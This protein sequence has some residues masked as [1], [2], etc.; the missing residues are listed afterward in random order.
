MSGGVTQSPIHS[1]PEGVADPEEAP[2]TL[3]PLTWPTKGLGRQPSL[4]GRLGGAES[5]RAGTVPWLESGPRAQGTAPARPRPLC[6]QLQSS[7]GSLKAPDYKKTP[8]SLLFR[9]SH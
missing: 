9:S 6:G 4:W 5:A 2:G 1:N 8:E 7:R 3:T